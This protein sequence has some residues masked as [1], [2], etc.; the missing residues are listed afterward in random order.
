MAVPALD[1]AARSARADVVDLDGVSVLRGGATLLDRV[2]WQVEEG[3]RWAVLGPNGAGKTTLLQV[4]ATRVHPTSGTAWVLGERLG[5]VDVFELRP[6]IGLA[7]ARL[8]AQ[9]A[10]GERVLDVVVTAA[11][12]IVGRWREAYEAGDLERGRALLGLM[13][14]GAMVQR[15]FGTLSEGERQRVLVAR[16][17]MADPELLLL[18]EPAA[19]LDLGGREDLVA[20]LGR[21]AADLAAPTFVLVTHHVEEVPVGTTHVLLLRQGRVVA[22]GPAEEALTAGSLSEAF[23]LSVALDRHAGRWSARAGALDGR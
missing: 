13:G 22:A 10:P 12:G 2:D 4:A 23:G 7:S 17:L 5:G 1:A 9:V 19:G 18:D 16:A 21:L 14:V 15:P 11:Y 6:R 20:R 3:E 8:A